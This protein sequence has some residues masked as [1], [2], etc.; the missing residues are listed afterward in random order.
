MTGEVKQSSEELSRLARQCVL[1]MT[2]EA[3]ASHVGSALSVIDILSVLHHSY[4]FNDIE[5]KLVFSKGHAASAYYSI[6]YLTGRISEEDFFSFGKNGTFLGGHISHQAAQEI[7]LSTG[8]LGHG[9]PYGV[10]LALAEKLN[11]SNK[12]VIIII[13]DGECDEGTTWESALLA[14]KLK[15][16]NLIVIIDRNKIQSLGDTEVIMPLEPLSSKWES[17]NWNTLIIDGHS[18]LEIRKALS[19]ELG[20][21]CVV[22]NTI[23]G[24]GVSFMENSVLW[25]YRPPSADDLKLALSELGEV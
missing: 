17:F 5:N 19:S 11:G 24:K 9:F 22:A 10:G 2:S 25:H 15:L 16:D 14:N 18:H 21:L 13:S 23:K 6:L 20:P 12:K 8:S 7:N 4:T 3:S 1:R